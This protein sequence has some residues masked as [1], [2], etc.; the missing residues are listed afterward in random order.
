MTATETVGWAGWALNWEIKSHDLD[1]KTMEPGPKG[2]C[3]LETL[4]SHIGGH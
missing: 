2:E 4:L 3:C 1:N